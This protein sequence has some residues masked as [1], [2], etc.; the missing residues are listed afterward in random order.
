M[1][2]G[3]GR[4]GMGR[5]P[6]T[7]STTHLLGQCAFG[8]RVSRTYAARRELN[9]KLE[10]LTSTSPNNT[11]IR[12][13][14]HFCELKRFAKHSASIASRLIY[15]CI[16][17]IAIRRTAREVYHLDILVFARVQVLHKTVRNGHRNSDE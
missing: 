2:F 17:K 8:T 12:S 4:G 1:H 9:A 13:P 7:A 15:A 5:R 11:T 6:D 16:I 3:M 14:K 10:L